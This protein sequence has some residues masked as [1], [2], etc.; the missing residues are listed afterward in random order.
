MILHN[1]KMC[2]MGKENSKRSIPSCCGPSSSAAQ[3]QTLGADWS[4][5]LRERGRERKSVCVCSG[6]TNSKALQGS[7][8]KTLK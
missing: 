4:E 2:E 8:Y 5:I 1:F 7:I 3:Q 6:L